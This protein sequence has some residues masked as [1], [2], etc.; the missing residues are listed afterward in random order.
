MSVI[1]WT[2]EEK[3]LLKQLYP[4]TLD[5]ND[6]IK[7]LKNKSW[8]AIKK[9]AKEMGIKREVRNPGGRPKKKPKQY[10]GKKQLTEILRKDLTID[11]IAKKLR[12]EPHIVRRYIQKYEL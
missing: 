11:E 12:A 3:E 7:A 9:Q 10:L 1:W 6:I 5:K 8:Y 4:Q 2:D